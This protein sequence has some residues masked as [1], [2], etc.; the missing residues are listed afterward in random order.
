[1]NVGSSDARE[2]TT[3]GFHVGGASIL[4]TT[5]VT[6]TLCQTIRAI[7]VAGIII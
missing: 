6:G 5:G 2:C 3:Y 4:M 1:M 7:T